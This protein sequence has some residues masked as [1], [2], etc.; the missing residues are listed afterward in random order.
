MRSDAVMDV[1]DRLL[2]SVRRTPCAHGGST[3][4]YTFSAGVVD[5]LPGENLQAC[6]ERADRMLYAAKQA[7]RNRVVGPGGAVVELPALPAAA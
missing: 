5:W 6:F 4:A 1:A 2:D 3:I 7:G